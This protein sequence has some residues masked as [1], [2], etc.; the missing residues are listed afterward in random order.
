M[1]HLFGR[2]VT[3]FVAAFFSF[4]API[5]AAFS[6]TWY[7][8]FACRLLLGFG[9]GLKDVT[10]PIFSAEVA[11]TNIRGGLVMSWQMWT[12][13]GIFLGTCANLAVADTGALSWRLQ[14][15]SAFI[16]A[17]PLVLGVFFCP[18]SPRWL[19]S[20]RRYDKAYQSLCRLRNSPLQAARDL[21]FI[22]AQIL[23]EELAVKEAGFSKADNFVTR[24]L[25]I[26]KV[27][28]L[29]RAT[30]ASGIAMMLQPM[31]GSKS[32]HSWLYLYYMY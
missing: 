16:P 11:P 5:G 22:Q 20:K 30:Q 29:R 1:N 9:M 10:V 23:Q 21:Y 4:F 17:V 25:E 12:A 19:I 32:L 15:G 27:P 13:F 24:F 2:R 7:Q 18:E 8:L 3:I 26:F 6:Q 14:L 31:C 28:R